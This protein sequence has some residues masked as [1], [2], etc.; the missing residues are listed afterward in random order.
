MLTSQL[1]KIYRSKTLI[2]LIHDTFNL[3]AYSLKNIST[4]QNSSL[5]DDYFFEAKD[6]LKAQSPPSPQWRCSQLKPQ[7]KETLTKHN[8]KTSC[9]REFR[10]NIPRHRHQAHLCFLIRFHS[11]HRQLKLEKQLSLIS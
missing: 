6:A 4:T 11:I 8:G 3:T 2:T 10:G 7:L 5:A 9:S 1:T